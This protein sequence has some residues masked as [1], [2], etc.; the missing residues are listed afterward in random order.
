M[1][2]RAFVAARPGLKAT[3]LKIWQQ[4]FE[5]RITQHSVWSMKERYATVRPASVT[6]GW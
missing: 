4:A 3:G 1:A 6:H 5:Q 2:L